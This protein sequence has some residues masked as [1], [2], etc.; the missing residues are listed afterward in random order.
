VVL[1]IV[2]VGILCL[3]AAAIALGSDAPPGPQTPNVQIIVERMLQA[4]RQN[5]ARARAFTVK[6]GY[7]LRDKQDQEKAHIVASITH[8]PPDDRQYQVESGSGGFGEKVLRDVLSKDAERPSAG[9]RAEL[10]P[11][12]YDFQLLGEAQ[13]EGRRCYLLRLNP[14]REEK[15]LLRG[16]IWVDA[17]TYNIRRIE[18][19]P[20]KAPSWW[21]RDLHVLMSFAEIDG[22]WLRTFTHA[23]AN[24]RFKGRYVMESRD[25]EYRFDVQTASRRRHNP[26]IL[27]GSAVN[28]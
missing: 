9:Q 5:K 8:V 2:V 7:L 20:V 3:T 24:V 4:Q 26:A 12:N 11:R 6:R 21:I 10:S 22:M 23:V 27:A 16:Q 28:P 15:D 17:E 14:R 1:R 18:G 25:L 19:S 13:L